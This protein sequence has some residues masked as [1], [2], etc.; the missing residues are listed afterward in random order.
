MGDRSDPFAHNPCDDLLAFLALAKDM[1]NATEAR[2]DC[3]K[4]S[5][6]VI[7]SDPDRDT[8]VIAGKSVFHFELNETLLGYPTAVR[9]R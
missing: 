6:S 8:A 3:V 5:R 2:G 4:F 9:A 7:V 1:P